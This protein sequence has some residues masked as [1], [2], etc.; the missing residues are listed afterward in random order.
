MVGERGF[1]PPTSSSRTKRAAKLRHSPTDLA[2]YQFGSMLFT[3]ML[4]TSW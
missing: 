1:E 2:Y 4:F 3:N